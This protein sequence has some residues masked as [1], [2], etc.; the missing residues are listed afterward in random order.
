MGFTDKDDKSEIRSTELATSKSL[1]GW[2]LPEPLLIFGDGK[3]HIDPKAGLALYGPLKV[4]AAS[5]TTPLSIQVG[6]IGSGETIDLTNRWIERLRNKIENSNEKPFQY[7]P[8]PGFNA[9]FNCEL[10]TNTQF[11]EMVPNLEI[12]RIKDLTDFES[13][14]ERGVKLFSDALT[15]VAERIPRPNMLICA[16]PQTVVDYCVVKAKGLKRRKPKMPKS[17]RE[18]IDKIKRYKE[19]GQTFLEGFSEE[20]EKMLE[21]FPET[22]DFW[23]MLK[24]HAMQVNIPTQIVWPSTLRNNE[25]SR[26]DDASTAWNFSVATYYKGSGFPWTMTDMKPGTCYIGISF[27]R[28]L[29]DSSNKMRTALAQIF[30]HTGE[31]LVLRGDRFAWDIALDKSPHLDEQGAEKLMRR[32]IELYNRHVNQPPVR[33]VVHKTSRYWKEELAGLKKAIEGIHSYDFVAFGKRNIRFLRY[34]KYPPLRGTVIQISDRNYLLYTRGYIPY[35]KTYPGARAPWP[36]EI[37]EHMGDSSIDIVCTEILALTKMNWNSA[38]F[39]LANP[40][41]I[42]FSERVGNVMASLP[43]DVTPKHEYLYYM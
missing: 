36:L 5:R 37:I 42:E 29:V 3:T 30:T 1:A 6:V 15:N 35:L 12:E 16:L 4:G 34:G 11:N 20:F 19:V 21:S 7:P 23:R 28:D 22:T 40:I 38:E 32:A 39:S 13:R 25:P 41:T 2:F 27:F 8:F 26:Q 18:L 10:I 33:V 31:G 17:Q 9:V 24:A 43:Q 14:V